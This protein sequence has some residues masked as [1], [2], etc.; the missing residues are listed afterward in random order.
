MMAGWGWQIKTY[1]RRLGHGSF[2]YNFINDRKGANSTLN[3]DDI[4]S[5]AFE[6]SSE[7]RERLFKKGL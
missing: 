1:D 6:S 3:L 4:N 2:F 5:I 7:V